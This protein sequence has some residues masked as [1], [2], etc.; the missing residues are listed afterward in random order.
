MMESLDASLN[1]VYAYVERAYLRIQ[2]GD[3]LGR[4]LDEGSIVPMQQV[5]EGLVL[6][7]PQSL[8]ILREMLSE[9]NQRK[10]QVQDDLHQV[11]VQFVASLNV[12]GVQAI[13]CR[14]ALSLARLTQRRFLEMLHAQNLT[15]DAKLVACFQLLHETR[16]LIKHLSVKLRVLEDVENYL[17]DWM[18]G[19]VYDAARMGERPGKKKSYQ[20]RLH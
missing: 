13:G 12:Y 16:S 1:S 20:G 15:D 8:N 19:V 3:V 6:A 11:Y 5:V 4:C 17:D 10:V 14:T 7:G 2:A 18:L 9:S